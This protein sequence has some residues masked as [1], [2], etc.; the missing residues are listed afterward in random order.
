MPTISVSG[1]QNGFSGGKNSSPAPNEANIHEWL[2]SVSRTIGRHS[3]QAGGGWAE[4]NYGEIIRNGTVSFSGS[5]TANFSGNPVNAAAGLTTAYKNQTGDGI[6]S[7]LLDEPTSA[8]KRNVLLTERLGGIANMYIQD[9]WKVIP[10][11]TLTYGPRYDRTVIPQYGTDASIGHQGSIETGDF[12]FNTGEYILQV[13][14]P[15]CAV[16]Q[17]AVPAIGHTASPRRRST[18]QEN[19]ARFQAQLRTTLWFGGA[20]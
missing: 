5:Q 17:V 18:Q 15:T 9:S 19:P 10:R 11:L 4:I 7:F 13:A 16:R 12:D 6:A 20:C 1:G 2:G 8:T 14:P 3:L